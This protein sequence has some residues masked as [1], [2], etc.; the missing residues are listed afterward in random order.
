MNV[1]YLLSSG[2]EKGLQGAGGIEHDTDCM[3]VG[4]LFNGNTI[5]DHVC[6]LQLFIYIVTVQHDRIV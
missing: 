6:D 1:K 5:S 2:I 4:K 3:G